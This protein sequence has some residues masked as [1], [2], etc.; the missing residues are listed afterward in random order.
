M[1]EKKELAVITGDNALEVFTSNG[2]LDPY[3]ARIREEIDQFV[4]DLTTKTG[5]AKIAS[6]AMKIAKSKTFIDGEGKKL[7][8]VLKEKPKIIDVSR[9]K[10]RKTLDSW[11]DEVREP[12]T[13]WEA[14]EKERI[15]SIN[16]R[17]NAIRNLTVL[18]VGI[19]STGLDGLLKEARDFQINDSLAEFKGYGEKVRNDTMESLDKMYAEKVAT[20]NKDKEL[21]E[22]KQKMAAVEAEKAER[23]RIENEKAA[24]QKLIDDALATEKKVAQDKIDK[25]EDDA[26]AA[27]RRQAEAERQKEEAVKQA[28]VDRNAA[29]ERERKAKE[30]AE[31]QKEESDRQIKLAAEN[32]IAKA[33]ALRRQEAE[34]KRLRE[35]DVE[36]RRAINK[37]SVS[38]IMALGIMTEQAAKNIVAAIAKNQLSKITINY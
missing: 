5:R 15:D 9:Q 8:A 18:A 34:R 37:L 23:Q 11:R 36:N 35:A 38:E 31:R 32:E 2:G 10:L 6:M 26:R 28:E 3:L 22:L 1:N 19:D 16:R 27:K 20:E 4:P 13:K 33:E 12:L 14:E 7:V 24:Q 25:V 30:D 17:I 29:A 21:E